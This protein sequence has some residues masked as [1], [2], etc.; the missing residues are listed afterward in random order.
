MAKALAEDH[1]MGFH[2]LKAME[3]NLNDIC[4][5]IRFNRQ[6]W[7]KSFFKVA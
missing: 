4:E 1:P 3:D 7:E 6:I 5:T 2:R